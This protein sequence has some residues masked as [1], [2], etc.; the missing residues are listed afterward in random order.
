MCTNICL[1]ISPS[2]LL[3]HLHSS[4]LAKAWRDFVSTLTAVTV[5]TSTG[6]LPLL[7]V[8]TTSHNIC[9][10]FSETIILVILCV[11]TKNSNDWCSKRKKNFNELC[12]WY[13][14]TFF[15]W[16]TF[17]DRKKWTIFAGKWKKG[18]I[19]LLCVKI[20]TLKITA[21]RDLNS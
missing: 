5:I 3:L 4:H 1:S 16:V 8:P 10:D 19:V 2:P 21:K 6:R 9:Y 11:R 15:M 18:F 14:Y 20:L 12:I 13:N 17:Q 7:Y